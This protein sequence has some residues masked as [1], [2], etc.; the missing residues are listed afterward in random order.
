MSRQIILD[1]ETT[2][3]RPEEGHRIIEIGAVEIIDRRFTKNDRHIYINPERPIDEGAFK[4]HGI[5]TQFLSDKPVFADIAEDFLDYIKGA[6]LII[7]NAPFDLNFLDHEYRW[8]NKNYS[9]I[10][11]YCGII[12]TLVMARKRHAGQRNSLD[13]LCKRYEINN[14]HRQLHGARLDALLLAEVFLRMTGGQNSLFDLTTASAQRTIMPQKHSAETITTNDNLQ[15]IL[16]TD[17]E[18]Q[19]HEKYLAKMKKKGAC[20]WSTDESSKP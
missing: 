1:T 19:E 7:H 2:G 16:A 9:K 4:V 13:A 10:H 20:V 17:E 18:Q 11:Q 3:L 14:T 12:D 6:E 8:L 5:S 15:V